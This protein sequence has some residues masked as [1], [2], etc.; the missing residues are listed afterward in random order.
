MAAR[1]WAAFL[2]PDEG[3]FGGFW[4]FMDDAG[5]NEAPDDGKGINRPLA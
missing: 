4:S 1:L 3:C 2:L 5:E